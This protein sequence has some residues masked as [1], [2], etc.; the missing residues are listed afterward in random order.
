MERLYKALGNVLEDEIERQE[1]ILAVCRAQGDAALARDTEALENHTTA[2]MGLLQDAMRAEGLR[3]ELSA[4]LAEAQGRPN[5]PAMT[6]RDLAA[7]APPPWNDRFNFFRLR[8]REIMA[9]TR[10]MVIDNAVLIRTAL[11]IAGKSLQVLEPEFAGMGPAYSA[12][13]PEPVGA[14]GTA[15]YLDQRG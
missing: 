10:S 15:K 6:L 9:E 13:G 14:G 1:N 7:S 5:A 11:R 2:L 8:L 4:R 12:A 3:R